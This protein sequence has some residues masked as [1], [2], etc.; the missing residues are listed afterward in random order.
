M[1]VLMYKEE[2]LEQIAQTKGQEMEQ[3]RHDFEEAK[4]LNLTIW[5]VVD[6]MAFSTHE[7]YPGAYFITTEILKKYYNLLPGFRTTEYSEVRPKTFR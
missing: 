4:K 3:V 1:K 5:S 7:L 2:T 6:F